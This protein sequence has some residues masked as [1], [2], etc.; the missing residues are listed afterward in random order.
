MRRSRLLLF[1]LYASLLFP[2]LPLRAQDQ[3]TRFTGA[4]DVIAYFG[5]VQRAESVVWTWPATGF[6][7]IYQNSRTVR[8]HFHADNFPDD[9]T[10]GTTKL[11]WYRIDD[12]PWGQLVIPAGESLDYALAAPPD[13]NRHLLEVMKASE[14]QVT[15]D[16]ILL[17]DGGQLR[18]PP[19]FSRRI[20]FVGDSITVGLRVNGPGGFETPTDHDAR[21]S[22]SWLLGEKLDAEVRL[23]AITAHGLVHNYGAPSGASKTIPA[24]YPYL[25]RDYAI[26]NDWTW[27]PDTIIVNL[28]TNDIAPPDATPSAVFQDAYLKFLSDL[29]ADNPHARIVV[30]Q[31]FGVQYG[32]VAIYPQE[33]RA[34]VTL[35]QHNG[36]DKV[37]YVDTVGWLGQ[38]DFT[39]GTH[40]NA[41]GQRK[42]ADRLV[43]A[44]QALGPVTISADPGSP[45]CENALPTRLAIGKQA[46]VTVDGR[47]PSPLLDQPDG[48]T[49][50]TAP[51]GIVLSIS[52]GPRCIK[53]SRFWLVQMPDGSA[54]WIRE[55]N[56]AS[57]FIEPVGN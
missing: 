53:N 8:L 45:M 24:Y 31:P 28:G 47:G 32:K 6:R 21:A 16:A 3:G 4:A 44:L 49:I 42:A 50:S 23:I 27:Q 13:K 38:D 35:R 26:A 36:D 46:R 14:G 12:R 19:A 41:Q 34:A 43:A 52:D 2:G 9:S 5:R 57:Y 55:N 15:F 10:L 37:F 56:G 48:R 29:R 22:Y 11:I 54:G 1:I 7:V 51:E 20:E 18:K 33:I 30:L 25:A 39:D 40:P 17:D